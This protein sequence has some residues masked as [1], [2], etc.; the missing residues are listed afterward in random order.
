MT[1]PLKGAER[2]KRYSRKMIFSVYNLFSKHQDNKIFQVKND[3][4]KNI[5]LQSISEKHNFINMH[6]ILKQQIHI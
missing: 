3:T 1:H 4:R 5:K 6:L 2:I